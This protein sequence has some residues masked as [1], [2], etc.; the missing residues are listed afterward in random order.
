MTKLNATEA[1][2]LVERLTGFTRGPWSTETD[3]S[4]MERP[5]VYGGD[6]SLICEAGNCGTDQDEWEANATL[7]SAAPDLHRHLTAALAEIERL[8]EG[9][10]VQEAAR[11][12]IPVFEKRHEDW[13]RS[14][15]RNP[16]DYVSH[17]TTTL[18]ALRALAGET[19][20]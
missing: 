9:L 7:T 3:L 5:R 10:T 1:R 4:Y 2:A 12:L 15:G 13:A 14:K 16:K 8:R 6:G 19:D 11:V 18:D 20:Q 17:H